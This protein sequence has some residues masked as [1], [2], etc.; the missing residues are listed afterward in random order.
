[1]REGIHFRGYAQKDPKQ[2]Y[3]KEGFVLFNS[4]R[5]GLRHAVLERIFKAEIRVGSR[6]QLAEDMAK[7]EA[8]QRAAKEELERRQKLGRGNEAQQAA[9]NEERAEHKLNRQQRRNMKLEL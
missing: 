6:E 7:L 3:K 9:Q 1:L 2:E 8:M 4:M 5:F